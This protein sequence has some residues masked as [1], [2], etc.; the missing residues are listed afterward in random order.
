MHVQNIIELSLEKCTQLDQQLLLLRGGGFEGLVGFQ[1]L[2]VY[3][4]LS[5]SKLIRVAVSILRT[6][7]YQ[8]CNTAG[9][10]ELKTTSGGHSKLSLVEA[11]TKMRKTAIKIESLTNLTLLL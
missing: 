1:S 10:D 9:S 6:D 4:S 3:H 8:F 11:E 5:L 2:K 7:S